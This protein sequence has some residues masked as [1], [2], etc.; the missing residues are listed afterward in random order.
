MSQ[1]D[2]L[3]FLVALGE[4]PLVASRSVGLSTPWRI[5]P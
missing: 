4:V 2:L 1:N 3:I 5:A